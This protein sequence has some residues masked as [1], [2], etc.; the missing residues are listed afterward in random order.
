MYPIIQT[1]DAGVQN[2]NVVSPI[3][4][5]TEA[6]K[7]IDTDHAYIHEGK[8][9]EAF[10]NETLATAATVI[11]TFTT[12][13]DKYIHY[14]NEKINTSGDKITVELFESAVIS[15]GGTAFTPINHNRVTAA[16][17]TV[18]ILRAPTL[19]TAGDGNLIAQSYIGGGTGT[20]GNR[21]GSETTNVNEYI[22]KRSTTY[23]IKITNGSAAANIVQINPVWYEEDMG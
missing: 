8:F 17:S 3:D 11:I 9:F 20:G 6:V 1:D 7:Q 10:F 14:R 23:V 18:S 16:T 13:A 21:S 15:T 22:L 2:I 4:S 12:P 5:F 19:A